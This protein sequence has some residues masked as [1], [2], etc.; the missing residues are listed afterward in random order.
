[1]AFSAN[2][3]RIAIGC[4]E[5]STTGIVKV[6]K[7]NG[8]EEILTLKGRTAAFSPDGKCVATVNDGYNGREYNSRSQE[9]IELWDAT[10]GQLLS[11]MKDPG[12]GITH[13]IFSADGKWIASA[14]AGNTIKV[15][16]ATTGKTI[17]TLKGHPRNVT[18]VAFSHDGKR[19]VSG[20]LDGTIK[21][22]NASNGDP[23]LTTKLKGGRGY[24]YNYLTSV[25]FSPDGKRI[26]GGT[27]FEGAK[28]WDAENGREVLQLGNTQTPSVACT[29]DGSRI[30]SGSLDGRIQLWDASSGQ[31]TLVLRAY[32][33]AVIGLMF[34][35][36]GK[37]LASGS[38]DGIIKIWDASS[39]PDT[40]ERA[41]GPRHQK[42]K[43]FR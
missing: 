1:L 21:I 42:G 11:A 32:K 29:P 27:Y 17:L 35:L 3:Q 24:T 16:D 15:W 37:R 33:S 23:V 20:S 12:S 8:G 40:T 39:S 43:G 26:I 22:W 31:E 13:P 25:I 36:D 7:A 5:F 18:C 2:G 19:M 34:S 28:I 9:S 38:S 14:S 4:S 41:R 10:N 30:A 6:L